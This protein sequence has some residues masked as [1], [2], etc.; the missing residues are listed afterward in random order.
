MTRQFRDE[1][2]VINAVDD[3]NGWRRFMI[4]CLIVGGL[5]LCL[6]PAILYRG[7]W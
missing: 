1:S 5:F 7:P 2:Y 4:A 6:L 3:P